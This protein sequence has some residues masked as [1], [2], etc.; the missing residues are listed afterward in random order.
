MKKVSCVHNVM[1]FVIPIEL[2]DEHARQTLNFVVNSVGTRSCGAQIPCVCSSWDCLTCLALQV[3]VR[4]HFSVQWYQCIP[5]HV[6]S[7]LYWRRQPSLGSPGSRGS[8]SD[9]SMNVKCIID[10]S[11]LQINW[12]LLISNAKFDTSVFLAVFH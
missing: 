11:C 12:N 10:V 2:F 5:D 3:L 6:N 8:G 4:V 9:S 1:L 7:F